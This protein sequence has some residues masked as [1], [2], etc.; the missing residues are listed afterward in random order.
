MI[1]FV[2]RRSQYA[3]LPKFEEFVWSA[4]LSLPFSLDDTNHDF[5]A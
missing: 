3:L 4:S 5:L 1:L 2:R